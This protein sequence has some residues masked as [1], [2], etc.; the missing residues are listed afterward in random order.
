MARLTAR[1]DLQDRI[2]RKLRL[3]RGDLERLDRLRRRSERPITLR[4]RDNATIALRRVRWFVLRD[5]ARTYQLTLDV[6]DLATKALRKFNGFLQRK[7]C[8]LIV[9]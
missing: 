2:T 9:C 7:I 6:N 3:I 4:V 8:V 5:L 1:F